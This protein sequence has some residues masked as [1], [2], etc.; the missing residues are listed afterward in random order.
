MYER[1]DGTSAVGVLLSG[2]LSLGVS[3]KLGPVHLA[4]GYSEKGQSALYLYLG[5]SIE[6]MR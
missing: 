4:Y 3:S 6:L 5:S 2:S 1:L